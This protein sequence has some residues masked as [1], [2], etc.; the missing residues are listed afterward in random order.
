MK[1]Y[2]ELVKM[3]YQQGIK[4]MKMILDKKMQELQN[5]KLQYEHILDGL[6]IAADSV[7]YPDLLNYKYVYNDK[8]A[9][10]DIV[11]SVFCN[12]LELRKVNEEIEVLEST[13][14]FLELY[15]NVEY[16]KG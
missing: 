11:N 6:K 9:D 16:L 7:G 1:T 8:Y 2:D 15:E 10:K 4:H 13:R 14:S 5:T 3:Q 12:M